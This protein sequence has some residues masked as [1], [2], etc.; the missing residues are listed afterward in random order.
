MNLRLVAAVIAA[1]VALPSGAFAKD[2][3]G[4]FVRRSCMTAG[5]PNQCTYP[6]EAGTRMEFMGWEDDDGVK[7][8]SV[9]RLGA[10]PAKDIKLDRGC[11]LGRYF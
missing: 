2:C 7:A 10:Y 6:Q 9:Y 4:T 11:K 8:Y 5:G 1:F 3:M